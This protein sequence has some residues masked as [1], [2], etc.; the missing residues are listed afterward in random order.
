MR[1]KWK[2]GEAEADVDQARVEI[3]AQKDHAAKMETCSMEME[4]EVEQSV[5][6]VCVAE[7]KYLLLFSKTQT[8]KQRLVT[9]VS[10]DG[11]M[12]KCLINASKAVL[13][14][15][16]E[17]HSKAVKSQVIVEELFCDSFAWFVQR[18][19]ILILQDVAALFKFVDD[20]V[21][22]SFI[23]LCGSISEFEAAARGWLDRLI[24]GY[25]ACPGTTA[26]VPEAD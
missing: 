6:Q 1:S 10:W 24:G 18:F 8:L 9:G 19:Q 7:S 22:A 2:N 26:A 13:G 21:S 20:S 5:S 14:Y 17:H 25:F 11:G 15:M 4:K 16:D 12:E 23:N 3:D